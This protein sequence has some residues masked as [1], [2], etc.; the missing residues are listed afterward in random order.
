[1]RLPYT[2]EELEALIEKSIERIKTKFC[3]RCRMGY[4]EGYRGKNLVNYLKCPIC[5]F[6]KIKPS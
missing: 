1:M 3:D 5:G 4:L 6:T 2:P